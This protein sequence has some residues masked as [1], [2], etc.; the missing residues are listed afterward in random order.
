MSLPESLLKI[1]VLQNAT[2]EAIYEASGV[3]PAEASI[4]RITKFGDPSF[5]I[6]STTLTLSQRLS[7]HRADTVKHPNQKVYRFIVENGGWSN[8]GA[9]STDSFGIELV[10]AVRIHVKST[11]KLVER[12]FQRVMSPS[13]NTIAAMLTPAERLEYTRTAHARRK[14]RLAIGV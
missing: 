12:S 1:V 7:T 10:A 3:A 8:D 9:P 11:L 5:Y 6:G 4:Y 14:A 2:A 13:L